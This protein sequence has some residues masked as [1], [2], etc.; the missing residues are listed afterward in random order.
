M[1]SSLAITILWLSIHYEGV[2]EKENADPMQGRR[3]KKIVTFECDID[4][5][6]IKDL[7]CF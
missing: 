2:L 5:I 3:E 4:L 1:E 6:K 7:F